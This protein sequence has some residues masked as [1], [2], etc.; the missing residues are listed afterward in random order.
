M[1]RFEF[2]NGFLNGKLEREVYVE[3]RKDIYSEEYR[4]HQVMPLK[5]SLYGLRDEARI[6]YD[7]KS[8]ILGSAKLQPLKS[9]KCIFKLKRTKVICYVDDLL[10]FA[11]R[12][13]R[14]MC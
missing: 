6:W 14:M 1:K 2:Q 7:L 10:L 8:S 5:R 12:G 3:L 4:K 13:K 11:D 9:S